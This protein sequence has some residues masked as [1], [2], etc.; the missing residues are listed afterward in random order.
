MGKIVVL[1]ERTIRLIAAGE[2]VERPASVVKELVENSID[3]G[4]T[5]ISVSLSEGGKRCISV[6][7]NGTG[8]SRDDAALAVERHTTSKIRGPDDLNAIS[9]L[10]FRGEA[11]ASIGAVSRMTIKTRSK[12]DV[13]GTRVLVEAGSVREVS[14]IGCPEGTEVVVEDLFFNVPARRKQMRSSRTELIYVLDAVTRH[15][16]AHPAIHFRLLHDGGEVLNAPSTEDRLTNIAYIY[17]TEFAKD[18][19]PVEAEYGEV[20]ITGFITHPPSA[21]GTTTYQSFFIN[22]RYVFSRMLNE[23]LR[24]GYRPLLMK[25]RHPGCVIWIQIPSNMVDVNVHPQKREVRFLQPEHVEEAIIRAVR[26]VLHVKRPVP[27]VT[28]SDTDVMS[29]ER[30]AQ[31]TL[32]PVE[33][34]GVQRTERLPPLRVL[35][36]LRD[37]YVIA[38]GPD[39]LYI[40]DQHAASERINLERARADGEMSQEL[41]E[42]LYL[43]LTPSEAAVMEEH[44]SLLRKMG[45]WV[46][47]FG[48]TS[49][50][51]RKVPSLLANDPSALRS[52]LDSLIDSGSR[53]PMDAVLES[54]ACHAAIKAGEEMT[55]DAMERLIRDL[56][57]LE[58]PWVCAHGRPTIVRLTLPE[59]E[60]KFKRK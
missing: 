42:P 50:A 7:D 45:F 40:I 14:A 53:D 26:S 21:R 31:R 34:R 29:K 56:A 16:L 35:G 9:T 60:R 36:Q 30:M 46:E 15:A 23:A 12:G 58:N 25:G 10:G 43:E 13:T 11:L 49:I 37:S 38:E 19:I 48:G 41:I 51:V 6:G 39:G 20:K 3:A 17:G 52:I 8:M 24:T 33:A 27:E 5:S 32:L 59:L 54:I 55:F 47:P 28:I 18:L 22:G 57:G 1:D 2:V 4:A 44:S